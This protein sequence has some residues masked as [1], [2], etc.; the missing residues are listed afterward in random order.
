M[1]KISESGHGEDGHRQDEHS[2]NVDVKAEVKV[3]ARAETKQESRQGHIVLLG[4]GDVGKPVARTLRGIGTSLV[5]VDKYGLGVKHDG[6]QDVGHDAK[7]GDGAGASG[8]FDFVVGDCV[9]EDVL[10]SAGIETASAIIVALNNDTNVIYSTLVS[11]TLNPDAII[12][13]RANSSKSIDKIYKAGADYVASLPII[14]GQMLAKMTRSCTDLAY[15]MYDHESTMLYEGIEIEKYHI[16]AHSK[17]VG[18]AIRELDIRAKYECTIIGIEADGY[19]NVDINP[20]LVLQDGMIVA[21]IG[22]EKQMHKF[23]ADYE[24]VP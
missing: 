3:K 4:Y 6:M 21:L 17:A 16:H 2:G 18:K 22:S 5:V 9:E 15:G 12:L 8:D 1:D 7:Q 10:I 14:A 20:D 24:A 11:R 23:K 19:V 13:A